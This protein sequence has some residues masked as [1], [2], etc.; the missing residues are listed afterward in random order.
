MLSVTE[1][2]VCLIRSWDNPG[3]IT[4]ALRSLCASSLRRANSLDRN[5]CCGVGTESE[6]HSVLAEKP[7]KNRMTSYR[8]EPLLLVQKLSKV[9][10]GCTQHALLLKVLNSSLWF[11]VEPT[12]NPQR[13]LN[14]ANATIFRGENDNGVKA[15]PLTG[16]CP[17]R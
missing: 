12:E 6:M 15:A 10:G 11:L 7:D 17:A 4:P 14:E 5:L 16:R 1:N 3:I 2:H 8:I 13:Q 9:L